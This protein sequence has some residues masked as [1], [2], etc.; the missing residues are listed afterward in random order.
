MLLTLFYILAGLCTGS[1]LALCADRLPRGESLFFPASHCDA[2][3]HRLGFFDLIPLWSYLRLGGRCRYCLAPLKKDLLW[4]EVGMGG[5]F[6]LLGRGTAPSPLLFL[7]F[8]LFSFLVLISVMDGKEKFVYDASLLF[9]I[10]GALFHLLFGASFFRMVGGS[11][12]LGLP[13]WM[14]YGLSR[15]RMRFGDVT[16]AFSLGLFLD[17]ERSLLT[18]FL[19]SLL[20]IAFSALMMALGR[21]KWRDP[22]PFAPFL[23][24]AAFFLF[25]RPDVARLYFQL[26]LF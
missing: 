14:I 24:T 1:F 13:L 2:C 10:G 3:G 7:T 21:R 16:L 11:L 5:S 12:F 8:Y 26:F 15:G 22:L 17:G 20:G 18:L 19:A 4:W 23:C 9:L 25:V 6:A